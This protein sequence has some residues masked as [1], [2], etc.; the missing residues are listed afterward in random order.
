MST[1]INYDE[2]AKP[3][4][5]ADLVRDANGFTNPNLHRR[6]HSVNGLPYLYAQYVGLTWGQAA[7]MGLSWVNNAG[8]Y[9]D[10]YDSDYYLLVAK[11]DDFNTNFSHYYTRS[12]EG[13]AESPYVYTPL[14]H[15]VTWVANR[16][17]AGGT[18]KVVDT[19]D[20]DDGTYRDMTPVVVQDL[21]DPPEMGIIYYCN[22]AYWVWVEDAYGLAG[23]EKFIPKDDGKPEEIEHPTMM[24]SR[25]ITQANQR[26]IKK[27]SPSTYTLHI[28]SKDSYRR[29]TDNYVSGDESQDS[30]HNEIP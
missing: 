14:T 6:V 10:Y 28:Q 1:Y 30:A 15:S 23:W 4:S 16:Y 25:I 18:A 12:G 13:T 21:P 24:R 22:G 29:K 20:G 7:D 19:I 5:A 26:K 17:Y 2:I 27:G 8:E 3:A 9:A 11:P